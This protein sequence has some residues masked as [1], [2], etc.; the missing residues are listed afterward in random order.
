MKPEPTLQSL[1][2]FLSLTATARRLG[3]APSTLCSLRRCH[4][5]Y[6]PAVIGAPGANVKQN[7]RRIGARLVRY[8]RLQVRLL[9]KVLCGSL[10]PDAALAEWQMFRAE[11]VTA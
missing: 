1:P 11:G 10:T 8:H 5:V 3:I 9:E 2:Q 4:A 6:A 7:G